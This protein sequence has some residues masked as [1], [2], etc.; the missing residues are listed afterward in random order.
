MNNDKL[1][2]IIQGGA[3]GICVLLIVLIAMI[4]VKYDNLANNH[5]REFTA[6]I[7]ES[8]Q[9]QQELI[10]VVKDLKTYLMFK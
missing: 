4:F 1:Q 6:A 3:I 2:K 7:K 10:N 5:S 8:T 9:V